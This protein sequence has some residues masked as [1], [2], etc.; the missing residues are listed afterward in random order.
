MDHA[1][2]SASETASGPN[3]PTPVHKSVTYQCQQLQVLT[4]MCPW[5]PWEAESPAR[6]CPAAAAMTP[7]PVPPATGHAAHLCWAELHDMAKGA[8]LSHTGTG[9]TCPLIELQ[10]DG[11]P[12]IAP[13]YH[14]TRYLYRRSDALASPCLVLCAH[15]LSSHHQGHHWAEGGHP[16][17]AS[18]VRHKAPHVRTAPR[19]PG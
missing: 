4:G 16:Q 12:S 1:E 14:S 6:A 7:S 10:P 5:V 11:P 15:L 19:L 8:E 2:D 3:A 18:Q 17:R 9:C 13:A